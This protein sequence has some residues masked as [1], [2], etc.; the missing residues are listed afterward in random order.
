MANITIATTDV[1]LPEVW[2]PLI[3][4]TLHDTTVMLPLVDRRY[5]AFAK[6]QRGD[7]VRVPAIAE[8]SSTTLTNMTGSIT[9]SANTEAATTNINIDTFRYTAVKIDKGSMVLNP[10]P[11]V[12]L[13]SAEIGRALGEGIDTSIMT[14][15][16]GTT[17]AVGL[18]NVA[19]H[20][21][22]ILEAKETLDKNNNRSEDRHSVWSAESYNDLIQVDKYANSLYAT[23]TG[24][25]AAG[26][27]DAY[28]GRIYDF[29]VQMSNNIPAGAAGNKNFMWQRTGIAAV[30]L[31][32]V[33]MDS[34][35]P[36]DEFAV[37]VRAWAIYGVKLMR[38]NSVIE[39]DA[40]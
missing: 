19:V 7:T 10:M 20:D 18:D 4:E 3:L 40:R 30:F 39:I 2:S 36:H 27:G 5:E 34:K 29:S 37:A 9:F 13:Y 38:A 21:G 28:K 8:I 6:G 17:N 23:S 15:M 14:A 11:I 33:Q 32:D 25:L 31:D 35:E 26:K 24:Q 12:E 1:L 16:D 22:L